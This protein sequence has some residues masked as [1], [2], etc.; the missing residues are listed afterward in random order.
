MTSCLWYRAVVR[1]SRIDA[2]QVQL[3]CEYFADVLAAAGWPDG[4]CLFLSG[5]H[6]A[7]WFSPA[8]IARVPDLIAVCA[9]E[10]SLP[11][12]RSYATLLVGKQRDWDLLPRTFH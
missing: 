2:R 11:P 8:A 9:A 5:R 6:D 10:P 12:D 1:D 4:A 3:I 7:V